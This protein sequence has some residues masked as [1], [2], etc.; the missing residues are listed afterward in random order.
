[1]AQGLARCS[2]L[3]ELHSPLEG[4]PGRNLLPSSGCWQSPLPFKHRTAGS[5]SHWLLSGGCSQ[6][7][8]AA[9]SFLPHRFLQYSYLLHQASKGRI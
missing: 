2:V 5:S 4:S 3:A 9:R 1:M 6:L 7:L 8:E